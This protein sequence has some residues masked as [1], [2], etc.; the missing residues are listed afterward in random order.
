VTFC[1]REYVHV[2]NACTTD[3]DGTA[4][5]RNSIIST[6][7]LHYYIFYKLADITIIIRVNGQYNSSDILA[8][9]IVF[10]V[11]LIVIIVVVIPP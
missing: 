2:Q 5:T 4:V 9:M 6:D 7:K 1:G 11:I 10:T 3:G 8:Q